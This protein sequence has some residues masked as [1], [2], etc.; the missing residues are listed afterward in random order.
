[1]TQ[2]PTLPMNLR[3]KAARVEAGLTQAQLSELSGVPQPNISNIEKGRTAPTAS[4]SDRI[5]GA[6]TEYMGHSPVTLDAVDG[7]LGIVG[8]TMGKLV[9]VDVMGEPVP[10]DW[11]A[12][13][14]IARGHVTMIAGQAGKGKSALT[15]TLAVAF[16]N[17]EHYAAGM[18]LPGKAQRVLILDAENVMIIS[19]ENVQASLLQ[20]RLQGFGIREDRSDN[21][22]AVGSAGFCLDKDFDSLDGL[23]RTLTDEKRK[24]DVIILDSFTSLWSGNENVVDHVNSVLYKLNRLAVLHN[25]GIVLIHHASKDGESF[26][27]SSAI[28]GAISAVFTFYSDDD[29]AEEY[30]RFA[31]VLAC[32]KMRI[33]AEPAPLIVWSDP[34]QQGKIIDRAPEGE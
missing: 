12:A 16:A 30:G 31:R 18:Q 14:Y 25:L 3:L 8:R 20:T 22:L 5:I 27:G 15:Q 23:L 11:L 34:T 13:G 6:I 32:Y 17:G 19:E 10:V 4:T 1:M 33:A 29:T 28:A 21:V 2:G 9:P 24:P 26:R 7:V